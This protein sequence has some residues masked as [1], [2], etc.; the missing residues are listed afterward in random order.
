MDQ[1]FDDITDRDELLRHLARVLGED[2]INR[3][4]TY[5]VVFKVDKDGNVRVDSTL[6]RLRVVS[7]PVTFV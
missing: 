6:S 3:W 5:R 4:I 2:G 1:N 7:A